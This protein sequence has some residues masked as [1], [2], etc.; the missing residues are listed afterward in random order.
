MSRGLLPPKEAVDLVRRALAV[1]PQITVVGVAGPGESLASLHALAA[2]SLV[3]Q[4]FPKLIG[5][6]STNGLKLRKYARLLSEVGVRTVSVTV[7][8]VDPAILDLINAGVRWR[9]RWITGLEGAEL[10]IREQLAGI[11]H[12]VDQGIVVKTNTVLIP[13]INDDHIEEVAWAAADAGGLD[14]ERDPPDSES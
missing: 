10:L 12:A 2:L 5:C 3:R 14:D 6:L 4:H 13:G 9:G 1:C 11:G 7:N 8:A